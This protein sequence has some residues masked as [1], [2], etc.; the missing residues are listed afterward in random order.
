MSK[1]FFLS[2]ND[3]IYDIKLFQNSNTCIT[4]LFENSIPDE[5]IL[6]SGFNIVN[7]HNGLIISDR[8][9]YNHIF[10]IIDDNSVI[11][12]N[13]GSEY[14]EPPKVDTDESDEEDKE[15]ETYEPTDEQKK[16]MFEFNKTILISQS[17]YIL[18]DFLSSNPLV[19]SCHNGKEG[20]YTVTSEKQ[21]LMANNYLT[22]TVAKKFDSSAKLTWNETG[23]ECEEWTEEEFLQ[24][25]LEASAYVK[26]LVSKQ[27]KY[28]VLINACT[29]QAELDSIV[30]DYSI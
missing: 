14:V 15:E 4:L 18:E 7:E 16:A 11:L 23:K 2:D 13:D 12:S 6:T 21:S 19:S 28:E 26:P 20:K 29:T 5:S 9:S 17:K 8:T 30:I 24:L 25:I 10:R 3:K 22:Y 1:I 27:Q